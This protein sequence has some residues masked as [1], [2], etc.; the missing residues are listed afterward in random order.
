MTPTPEAQ[1]RRN[2]AALARDCRSIVRQG[3]WTIRE[4]NQKVRTTYRTYMRN[5]RH[6][7]KANS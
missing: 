2:A 7:E 6:F 3:N 1:L 4:W 5:I